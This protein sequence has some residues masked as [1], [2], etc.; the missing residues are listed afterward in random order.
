MPSLTTY[1]MQDLNQ[2]HKISAAE[3][4]ARKL[5]IEKRNAY[6]EGN[7]KRWLIDPKTKQELAE[8]VTINVTQKI[9]DQ[10]VS[11]LFG[12]SPEI[13]THDEAIDMLVE[14]MEDRNYDDIFFNSLC[15]AGSI[16]GHV[17]V[18]L[19]KEADTVRWVMMNP[20]LVSVFWRPDDAKVANAYKIQW[21]DG[22][23]EY[24]QDIVKLDTGYW[25]VRDMK[26]SGYNANWQLVSDVIWPYDFAPI[27]D[28]QNLPNYLGYYGKTDLTSLEINDAI[29]FTASNIN[30]ILKHHAHPKTIGTGVRNDQVKETAVQGFWS[31]ESPD[32]KVYNLEMQSDLSAS[33][34]FLAFLRSEFF[35]QQRA[36]DAQSV[37]D[38]I[39]QLTNFGLRVLF[40]DAIQKNATKQLLYGYG[41]KEL[42]Y[43]S[44]ILMGV[45]IDPNTIDVDFQD[46]MPVNDKENSERVKLE[47]ESGVISK[48]TASEQLG[49]DWEEQAAELA[50]EKQASSA[51]LGNS[52]L[53]AMR[54]MDG[55]NPA[56]SGNMSI[57]SMNEDA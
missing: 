28:W 12:E 51:S 13:E 55:E 36:V 50:E 9:I 48:K 38:K 3:Y 21:V 57:D 23:D 11:L 49:Y 7:Q 5:E 14:K 25:L 46:P 27:V 54:E 31:I 24:R 15:A 10:S 34:N 45:S 42:V 37:K 18:K 20:A 8:N 26:R 29:N 35:S 30:M 53:N 22:K 32:A 33:M 19:I 4:L 6:Y 16:A 39:G 43:R 47:L 17:F 44:L 56:D 40:S 2:L 52:L 1:D 41:I